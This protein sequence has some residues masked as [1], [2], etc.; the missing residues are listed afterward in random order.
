MTCEICKEATEFIKCASNPAACEWYCEKC[1]KS[2]G[3]SMDD[4]RHF[5]PSLAARMPLVLGAD[6]VT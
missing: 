5:A 1:H 3:V 2:Y 6:A 4:M